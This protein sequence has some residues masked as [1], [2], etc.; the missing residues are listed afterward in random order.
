MFIFIKK[1][2]SHIYIS[3]LVVLYES[4]MYLLI[5]YNLINI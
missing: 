1:Y 2:I 4:E 3:D 5:V